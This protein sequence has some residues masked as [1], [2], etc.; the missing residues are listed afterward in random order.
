LPAPAD[1]KKKTIKKAKS[2]GKIIGEPFSSFFF[3]FFFF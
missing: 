2:S 3:L 1:E